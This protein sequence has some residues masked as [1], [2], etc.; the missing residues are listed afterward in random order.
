MIIDELCARLAETAGDSRLDDVRIGLGYTAV[1]L[2]TG[3]CG[4]AYTF[5]DEAGEC[6]S[7]MGQAGTIVGRQANEIAAWAKELN[8]VTAAV[9][10][11]TLNAL[12]EPPPGSME[13]DIAGR[14][15]LEPGDVVGMV[16]YFGPLVEFVTARASK[17]HIFERRPTANGGVLP[18]W[19]APVLLPECD[20]VLLS[21]T[22]IANRTADSLLECARQAREVV[23]LGPSAPMVPEV[24]AERG[25]TLLSGV[26]VVDQDRL[27]RIV[28]EGGGTRRFGTAVRKLVLRLNS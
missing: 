25:V 21:A 26:Q 6:C 24:F 11:A 4:L 16:G 7:V 17:L 1:R 20:V 22:T 3:T 14:L 8:A 15:R 23:V 18:D 2:D 27:L 12:V 5:R 13:A 10:L 28:S 19:A 9:G